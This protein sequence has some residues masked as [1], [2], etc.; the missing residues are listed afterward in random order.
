MKK[1]TVIKMFGS[2]T[3]VGIALGITRMA[4]SN[5]GEDIP[6]LRAYQVERLLNAA[7]ENNTPLALIRIRPNGQISRRFPKG[8]TPEAVEREL[9]HVKCIQQEI[10]CAHQDSIDIQ[11][12]ATAQ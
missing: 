11:Q 6:E 12:A 10:E 7:K 8:D 1:T 4:V 5:W 2:A 9:K 3:K